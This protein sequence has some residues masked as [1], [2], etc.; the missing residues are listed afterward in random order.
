MDVEKRQVG[1]MRL[2][3][4]E[5]GDAVAGPRDDL[6]LRPQRLQQIGQLVGQ[7]RFILG[8]DRGGRAGDYQ[9]RS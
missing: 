4:V 2:D 8:E 7:Q 1:R 5:R 9:A 3:G 6:Q